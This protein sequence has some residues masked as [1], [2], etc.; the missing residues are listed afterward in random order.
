MSSFL[1]MTLVIAM[2]LLLLAMPMALFRLLRGPT[3]ADRVLALDFLSILGIGFVAAFALKTE[4][5]A[6][7]DVGISLGLVAFLATVAFARY[8]FR[9]DH[10]EGEKDD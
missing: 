9:R 5:Y 3:V 10:R 6:F 7:L 8:I 4:R 2:V 1:D